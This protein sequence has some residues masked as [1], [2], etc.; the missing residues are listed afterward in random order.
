MDP[1]RAL[2]A[3]LT[4]PVCLSCGRAAPRR[5]LVLCERCEE[6]LEALR[7]VYSGPPPGVDLLWSAAPHR[8]VARDLVI[9]LK[10][11][12][13]LPVATLLAERITDRAPPGLL[14]GVLVAVPAAP[15]RL[16][17]RGFD[18]AGEIA[19][20]L[21]LDLGCGLSRCLQRGSG[22]RQGRGT[23]EERLAAALE[24]E[25]AG[26]VPDAAVLVDDVTTTGATL[27]ACAGALRR[28]GAAEVMAVTFT[29]RA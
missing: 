15:A 14:D 23:R 8:G 1:L 25:P 22:R 11:R 26:R 17:S 21:S 19:G 7:P 18:P 28:A 6:A 5:R 27:A 12:R 24:I 13:L 29:A 9:A 3:A 10:F 2:A 16:R 20:R 4:P